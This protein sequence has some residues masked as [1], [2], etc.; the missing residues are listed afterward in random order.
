MKGDVGM[1]EEGRDGGQVAIEGVTRVTG[2]DREETSEKE[3][4]RWGDG[5]ST[6]DCYGP[7][8]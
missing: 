5:I 3:T 2:G 1:G 6:E 8:G 4:E 7:R